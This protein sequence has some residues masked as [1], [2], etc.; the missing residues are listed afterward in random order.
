LIEQFGHGTS[1]IARKDS[2]RWAEDGVARIVL[3][4][5]LVRFEKRPHLVRE[6]VFLNQAIVKQ[7]VSILTTLTI[8]MLTIATI[9]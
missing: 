3:R 2:A 6:I 8:A 5:L 9:L 4:R 1:Y 7:K